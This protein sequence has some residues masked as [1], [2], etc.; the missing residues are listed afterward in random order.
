MD[1]LAK[2]GKQLNVETGTLASSVNKTK[3]EFNDILESY[4]TFLANKTAVLY[5]PALP[6]IPVYLDWLIEFARLTGIIMKGIC[7]HVTEETPT[8]ATITF[9]FRIF[10][11]PSA[12]GVFAILQ[13]CCSVANGNSIIRKPYSLRHLPLATE[14][15]CYE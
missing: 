4:R 3:K 14:G 6:K 9:P 7:V 5:F 15:S 2:V 10:I 1:W 8:Y 12:S 11:P 13:N